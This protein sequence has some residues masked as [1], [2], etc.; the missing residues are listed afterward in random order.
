MPNHVHM[1]LTVQD[2]G[3]GG[4]SRAPTPTNQKIPHFM[5][6]LKRFCHREIGQTIFQRS[7]YDHVIRSETGYHEIAQYIGANPARW[8]EDEFYVP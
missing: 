6:T 7:Y 5:S 3:N 1:I 4:S 8:T 2:A